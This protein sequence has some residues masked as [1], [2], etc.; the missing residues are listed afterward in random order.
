MS[1]LLGVEI[2]KVFPNL[3][4]SEHLGVQYL[5][6]VY[7]YII[8][9]ICMDSP[10]TSTSP[11]I[12]S[13]LR[14]ISDDKAL[15]LFNTIALSSGGS[16]YSVSSLKEMDLTTKQYYSRMSGLLKADLIKRHKRKYSLTILGKIVFD[17]HLNIGKALNYYWKFKAIEAIQTSTSAS[18]LRKEDLLTLIDTLIDNHQIKD[19]LTKEL[20]P[21]E[22]QA[23]ATQEIKQQQQ[24]KS[25]LL[26]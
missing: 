4:K 13:I 5:Y 12:T 16:G 22:N 9:Y 24:I 23:T 14:I 6:M 18:G 11:S 3:D 21:L 26:L 7:N 17:A 20:D 15:T 25:R 10:Q 8:R 1:F 19:I 2:S